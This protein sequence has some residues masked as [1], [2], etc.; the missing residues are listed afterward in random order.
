MSWT[1]TTEEAFTEEKRPEN[2]FIFIL[3]SYLWIEKSVKQK[4][5]KTVA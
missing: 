5:I 4:N 1:A 3:S 2:C